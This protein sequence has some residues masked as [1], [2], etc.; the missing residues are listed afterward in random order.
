MSSYFPTHPPT[1]LPTYIHKHILFR[2]VCRNLHNMCMYV[3]VKVHFTQC[4]C[5]WSV[6]KHVHFHNSLGEKLKKNMPNKQ[7]ILKW[8]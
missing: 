7:G 3:H 6:D 1:Y 2:D 5:Q 4:V 8:L